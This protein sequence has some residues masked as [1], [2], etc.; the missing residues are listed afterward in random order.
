MEIYNYMF[1]LLFFCVV[2]TLRFTRRQKGFKSNPLDFLILFFALVVPN[3]PDPEIQNWRMGLVAAKI[4]VMYFSYEVLLGE[5]REETQMLQ[6]TIL[7]TLIILTVR[8]T[9]PI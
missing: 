6:R 3:L 8:M 2:L 5:L 4:I 7:A 1:F 9:V